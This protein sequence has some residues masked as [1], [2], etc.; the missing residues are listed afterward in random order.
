MKRRNAANGAYA[1]RMDMYTLSQ[2]EKQK[3]AEEAQAA[4]EAQEALPSNVLPTTLQAL[5]VG[6]HLMWRCCACLEI[7]IVRILPSWSKAYCLN[8]CTLHLP[9]K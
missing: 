1:V 3:Q 5:Q 8:A 4:V 2:E 9:S 7:R 6:G